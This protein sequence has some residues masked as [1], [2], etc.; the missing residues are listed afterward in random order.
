MPSQRY[1]FPKDFVFGAATAAYQIEGAA[2]EDGRGDSIW[3]MVCRQKDFVIDGS[4][5]A[6]ADD[7]YHRWEQDLDL[8]KDLGLQAYRFS[9]AWPRVI[10]GGKGAVNEKGLAFYDRLVDGLL[11]RGIRPNATLYHWDLPTELEDADGWIN[12]DTA[13]RF[14]EYAEVVAKRLGDRVEFWATFNEPSVFVGLGYDSGY[15]APGKKMGPKRVNQAVH[16]VLLAHGLGI[17]A[18]RKHVT[19][20]DAKLGIVLSLCSAWPQFN[21]P[22]DIAAAEKR[23]ATE[24]DWW[25]LPMVQGRYPEQVW[26]D[27]GSDAPEVLEGDM[28]IIGQRLDY[29]GVNYY[30]PTRLVADPSQPQG[31]RDVPPAPNAPH[32]SM[33]NWEIFAPGLRSMLLQCARRY[34]LPLYVT[35]NGMSQ[36]FDKPGADGQVHDPVRIDFLKRHLIEVHRANAEGANVKGYFQWS[37]LDNFEWAL[38]Y[39]QRFG[40]VHVDYDTLKRTPKDSAAW[41]REVCKSGGFEAEPTPDKRSGF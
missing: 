26:K 19:Q 2:T 15:H 32:Q 12:R 41:Y 36:S 5:G 1:E 23:F 11:K 24:N 7:H 20:K 3:D 18:L 9:I 10:P 21:T 17:Q 33:P 30:V 31:W 27:K 22:A 13:Y 38:G 6:V 37:L 39:T 34:K 8:M 25:V 14:Q 40:L 4:S 16:N 29:L 28:A 35:E